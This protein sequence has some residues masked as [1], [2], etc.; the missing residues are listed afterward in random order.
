MRQYS[1]FKPT[2]K[3]HGGTHARGKRKSWRPLATKKPIHL[4]LKAKQNLYRH[5]SLIE[6]QVFKQSETARVKIHQ[7][8]VASDHVH[9]N[10]VRLATR[11]HVCLCIFSSSL[12]NNSWITTRKPAALFCGSPNPVLEDSIKFRSFFENEKIKVLDHDFRA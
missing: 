10:A 3:F 12:F 4:V 2:P 5:R 8:A 9:L 6:F 7:Q 11:H 1:F